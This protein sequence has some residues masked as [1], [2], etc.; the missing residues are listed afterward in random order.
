MISYS[1]LYHFRVIGLASYLSK[2]TDFN[3]PHL[4]LAPLLGWPR[5]IVAEIFGIKKLIVSELSW[6]SFPWSACSHFSRTPSWDR[7]T[8][9][10]T[11]DDSI[12]RVSIASRSKIKLE[13][14]NQCYKQL[15]LD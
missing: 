10:R 7:R 13:L 5:S 12:Y 4:H 8:D 9:G 6:A 1:I 2:V 11:H 15:Q 3:L 14:D